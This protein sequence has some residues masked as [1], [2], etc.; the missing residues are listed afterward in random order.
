MFASWFDQK[1]DLAALRSV[2]AV[3]HADAIAQNGIGPAYIAAARVIHE[4]LRLSPEDSLVLLTRTELRAGGRARSRARPVLLR[5]LIDAPPMVTHRRAVRIRRSR[6]RGRDVALVRR[7]VESLLCGV[8]CRRRVRTAI[9][10]GA[11]HGAVGGWRRSGA[12]A[13]V[14]DAELRVRRARSR[15]GH[16]L[17]RT[18]RATPDRRS[19]C[20]GSHTLSPEWARSWRQQWS[21]TELT[22]KRGFFLLYGESLDTQAGHVGPAEVATTPTFSFSLVPTKLVQ[23]FVE[24]CYRA[25]CS[26]ADYAGGA[27]PLPPDLLPDGVETARQRAALATAARHPVADALTAPAVSRRCGVHRRLGG[28]EPRGCARPPARDQAP[29]GA[30]HRLDRHRRRV[31]GEHPDRIAAPALRIRS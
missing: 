4:I 17:R 18:G 20:C 12:R 22:G 9:C 31:R 27:R 1:R 23:L 21:S 30:D 10:A 24:P 3:G 14:A 25:L 13:P 26:L 11:A 16:R 7:S 28:Q 8:P 29:R 5:Q 15:L 6:V 19:H 2:I